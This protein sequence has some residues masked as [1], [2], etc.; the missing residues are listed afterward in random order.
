MLGYWCRRT[1][2]AA[3]GVA[4]AC[5]MAAC[6]SSD[7][8][9]AAVTS[10]VA[11]Q[12]LLQ[13]AIVTATAPVN[14]NDSTPHDGTWTLTLNALTTSGKVMRLQYSLRWDSTTAGNDAQSSATGLGI[15]LFPVLTDTA[16]LKLYY[17]LCSKGRWEQAGGDAAENASCSA[18]ILWSLGADRASGGTV[19]LRNHVALEAA[20]LYSAPQDPTATYDVQLADGLPVFTGVAPVRG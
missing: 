15:D 12:Q 18:S 14:D 6:G 7:K 10:A 13:G 5:T 11:V 2:A 16:N 9:A 19:V 20:V 1:L 3:L 17:P 8:A 4:C